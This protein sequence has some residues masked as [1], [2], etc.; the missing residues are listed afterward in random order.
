MGQLA[1]YVR[2]DRPQVSEN[3][4][5]H[6][7][8]KSALQPPIIMPKWERRYHNEERWVSCSYSQV[9]HAFDVTFPDAAIKL[10]QVADGH[11]IATFVA[12]YRK[13]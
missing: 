6:P 9:E 10:A 11:V 7:A 2:A 13:A 12:T 4:V 8:V 1:D 5:N 3:L